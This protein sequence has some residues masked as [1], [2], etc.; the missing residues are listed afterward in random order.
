MKIIAIH[1]PMGSGKTTACEIIKSYLFCKG[2]TTSV[3]PIAKP[4]KDFAR[5]LG[6][7]GKKDAKGRRLLQLLGTECGRKC[8][9]EDIW[10]HKWK[11]AI[12]GEESD[13]ILCDDMRFLNEYSSIKMM[14]AY[15]RVI[16]IKLVG[17]GYEVHGLW[18]KIVKW[19]RLKLNMV[20]PS[21]VPLPDYLFDHVIDNSGEVHKLNTDLETILA[22]VI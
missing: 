15:D 13:V 2:I 16:M 7:D 3:V 22:K 18:K 20:H 11:Q 6:W 17:R 12:N 1:G 8:I 9:H 21:E 14:D 19:I 10:V 5:Q 4:L